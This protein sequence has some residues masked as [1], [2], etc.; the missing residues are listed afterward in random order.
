MWLWW[1]VCNNNVTLVL[2]SVVLP[3]THT[4][5]YDVVHQTIDLTRASLSMTL[6]GVSNQLSYVVP[7]VR[8]I[9]KWLYVVRIADVFYKQK[10][11][12]KHQYPYLCSNLVSF[13]VTRSNGNKIDPKKH[14]EVDTTVIETIQHHMENI[15]N[16]KVS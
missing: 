9:L 16:D 1:V 3:P 10:L 6:L 8:H 14:F 13:F 15:L 7:C 12:R 11:L 5:A 2:D 4:H